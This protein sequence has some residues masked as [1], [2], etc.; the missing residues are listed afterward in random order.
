MKKVY[1]AS[2]GLEAHMIADL[3]RQQGITGR[4]EGEYLAGAIGELPAAGLVRVVV[5]EEDYEP[6]RR[7]IEGWHAAQ[8]EDEPTRRAPAAS[9]RWP[10]VAAGLLL[11]VALSHAGDV[12][13]KFLTPA[14][15]EFCRP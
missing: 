12:M 2:H 15:I 7:V 4:V 1:E 8:P 3:L 9:A 6:A 10:Y 14:E 5:D 13:Q 11:G